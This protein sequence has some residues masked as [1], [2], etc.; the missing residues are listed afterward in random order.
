MKHLL[1]L[2]IET[3][4]QFSSFDQLSTQWKLLW[5]DK[6]SKIM[7]ESSP[8]ESYLQ[9]ASIMAEFG[10]VICIST[11][12]FYEDTGQ[13]LCFRLKS[14]YGDD[15][16]V[17][18]SQLVELVNTYSRL[19]KDF[20]F[21]GHNI[22]EFD[23]PYLCRRMTINGIN[24][25]EYLQLSGKK[26]WETNMADTMQLWKFGDYKH[27]TSLKLLAACLGIDTP[28]DDMDGSMVRTVYYQEKDIKRIVEYCQK[29]VVTTAQILLKL[30][31]MPLIPAENIFTA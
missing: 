27:F 8:A 14:L 25:P 11:G 26:P 6:I 19:H 30:R 12:F 29:D 17:V 18:L 5:A 20:Q 31:N 24:L 3:V 23:I 28:K 13:R 9:K 7:P 21:A 4:P 16:A 22:K 1:V 2:D 15:E 10:K